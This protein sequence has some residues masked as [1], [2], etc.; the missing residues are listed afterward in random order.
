MMLNPLKIFF[1]NLES[2][3]ET[4]I[5]VA[6]QWEKDMRSLAVIN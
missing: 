4:K 2:C 5:C 1:N 3:Q 6:G